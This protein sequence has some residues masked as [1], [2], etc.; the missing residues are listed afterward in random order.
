MKDQYTVLLSVLCQGNTMQTILCSLPQSQVHLQILIDTLQWTT[1]DTW[2]LRSPEVKCDQR[3]L[4]KLKIER[5][6][7]Q[8][9]LIYLIAEEILTICSIQGNKHLSEIARKIVSAYPLSFRGVIEDQVGG[10]GWVKLSTRWGGKH[11][12]TK[13]QAS[14]TRPFLPR[15]QGWIVAKLATEAA[16]TRWNYGDSEIYKSWSRGGHMFGVNFTKMTINNVP[17]TFQCKKVHVLFTVFAWEYRHQPLMFIHYCITLFCFTHSLKSLPLLTDKLIELGLSPTL[18]GYC[19]LSSV[20]VS[21]CRYLIY[22][23]M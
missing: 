4:G 18:T 11:L 13:I 15:W 8:Q 23:K 22:Q 5:P 9:R 16:V 19:N 12:L 21:H 14:Y 3:L 20:P 1:T 2:V 10:S 6:T 7:G 17:E